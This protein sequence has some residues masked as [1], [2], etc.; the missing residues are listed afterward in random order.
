MEDHSIREDAHLGEIIGKLSRAAGKLLGQRFAEAGYDL[1]REHWVMLVKLWRQEGLT[2][3][4]LADA[5]HTDKTQVTRILQMFES[6]N[7][8]VRVPDQTD[9][10]NNLVYLTHKG[11]ALREELVP[12][13]ESTM[14]DAQAGISDH[15]MDETK[16]ILRQ[17]FENIGR[18]THE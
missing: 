17:I 12:I 18:L 8:V 3:Q 11:K 9:R 15:K 2:Q 5:C 14:A 16:R 4:A 1:R 6:Q 13:V 7:I 10:R